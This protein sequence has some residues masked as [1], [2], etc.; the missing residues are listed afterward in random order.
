MMGFFLF[1][2]FIIDITLRQ[3]SRQDMA[4]SSTVVMFTTAIRKSTEVKNID[5]RR[6][7]AFSESF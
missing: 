7:G 1:Q 2:K 4:I 6:L 3:F 5:Q